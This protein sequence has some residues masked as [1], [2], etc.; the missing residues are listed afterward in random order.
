MRRDSLGAG[1]TLA[2]LFEIVI[3]TPWI[4]RIAVVIGIALI[5]AGAALFASEPP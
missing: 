1:L 4:G 5:V 2:G 3:L